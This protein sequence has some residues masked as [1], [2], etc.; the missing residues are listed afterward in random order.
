ML[1]SQICDAVT[2]SRGTIVGRTWEKSLGIQLAFPPT[3]TLKKSKTSEA[4]PLSKKINGE[5]S[6]KND[7]VQD[8]I[9]L[10]CH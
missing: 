4:K 8:A 2:P 6:A 1:F 5:M 9:F 10:F 3:H 7:K